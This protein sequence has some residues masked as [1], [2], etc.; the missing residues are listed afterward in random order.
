MTP[1]WKS[2]QIQV[3]ITPFAGQAGPPRSLPLSIFGFFRLLLTTTIMLFIVEPTNLYARQYMKDDL[4]V[5]WTAVTV[6]EL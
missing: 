1:Q 3:M 4:F 2:E 5:M 6:Q